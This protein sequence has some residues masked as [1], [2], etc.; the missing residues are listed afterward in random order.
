MKIKATQVLFSMLAVLG[1]ANAGGLSAKITLPDGATRTARLEGIGCNAAICSRVAI[2]GVAHGDSVIQ[3]RFS[4]IGAIKETTSEGALFVLK[5]GTAQRLSLIKDFRV[6][7]LATPSGG[8]EKLDLA[9]VKSVEFL[10]S[11]K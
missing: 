3:T 11:A 4:A 7:Y 2:K 1:Q 9:N 10:G 5:N 8:T 6:L